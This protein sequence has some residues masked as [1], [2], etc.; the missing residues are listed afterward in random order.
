M[1]EEGTE[2]DINVT[3]HAEAGTWW[4]ESPELPGFTAMAED[5]AGIRE[6]VSDAVAEMSPGARIVPAYRVESTVQ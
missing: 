1:S 4:A 5:F 2:M 3:Y 6:L